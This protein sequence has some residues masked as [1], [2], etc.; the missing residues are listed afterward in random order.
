MPCLAQNAN[1]GSQ[2]N[3]NPAEISKYTTSVDSLLE[4]SKSYINSN[5]DSARFFINKALNISKGIDY[6]KGNVIAYKYMC[7]SYANQP[8]SQSIFFDSG[9]SLYPK[10][11]FPF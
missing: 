2:K 5:N 1:K 10:H 8:E 11:L 4:L 9:A 7:Y 3:P 6:K